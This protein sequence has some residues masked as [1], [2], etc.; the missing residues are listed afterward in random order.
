M[1]QHSANTSCHDCFIRLRLE[2]LFHPGFSEG[3]GHSQPFRQHW[4]LGV[5]KARLPVSPWYPAPPSMCFGL[6]LP[7]REAGEGVAQAWSTPGMQRLCRFGKVAASH[8]GRIW[9]LKKKRHGQQGQPLARFVPDV[10]GSAFRFL[11]Q[12]QW[13]PEVRHSLVILVISTLQC[14]HGTFD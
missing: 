14:R 10:I 7:Q 3:T 9:G 8:S 4:H 2:L 5:D 12:C 1:V 11:N 6:V 13:S